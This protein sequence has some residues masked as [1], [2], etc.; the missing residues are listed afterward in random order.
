MTIP[1]S[2]AR[3]TPVGYLSS[4]VRRSDTDCV[5]YPLDFIEQ[6]EREQLVEARVVTMPSRRTR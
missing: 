1:W 2:T 6:Y 5:I 3:P 4:C